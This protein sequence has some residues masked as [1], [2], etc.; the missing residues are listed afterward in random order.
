[1]VNPSSTAGWNGEA[2]FIGRGCGD[3]SGGAVV[4]LDGPV[5]KSP[6]FVGDLSKESS[7]E[8]LGSPEAALVGWDCSFRNK[9]LSEKAIVESGWKSAQIRDIH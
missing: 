9:F 5:D 1:M 3:C 6:E 7:L 2:L 4:V 8:R